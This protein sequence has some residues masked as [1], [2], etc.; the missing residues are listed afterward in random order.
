[1]VLIPHAVPICVAI[2]NTFFGIVF[3][4]SSVV[5]FLLVLVVAS[6]YWI[7]Y[8]GFY[9]R[10]K[11]SFIVLGAVLALVAIT[12]MSFWYFHIRPIEN[13][14]TEKSR[15]PGIISQWISAKK[16]KI[17]PFITFED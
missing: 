14:E 2:C 6:L 10:T 8:E 1:M 9:L 5:S 17:C 4:F 11:I 12:I 13:M 3:L 16:Q 7:F 15:K